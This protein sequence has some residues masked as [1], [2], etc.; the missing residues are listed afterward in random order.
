MYWYSSVLI[1]CKLIHRARWS[2]V[3]H[4]TIP[5]KNI[6]VRNYVVYCIPNIEIMV[7][8]SIQRHGDGRLERRA[9]SQDILAIQGLLYR[10]FALWVVCKV[11]AQNL[12]PRFEWKPYCAFPS[13]LA[14]G[15]Q[16]SL[17]VGTVWLPEESDS[18]QFQFEI[19]QE[20]HHDT[21][22]LMNPWNILQS[23]LI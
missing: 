22:Y 2:E 8:I 14:I 17:T 12:Q 1:F 7:N 3:R 23:H 19:V 11:R 13:L 18:N 5:L 9:L 6:I 21:R 10:V 4:L 16:S 15:F 20:V